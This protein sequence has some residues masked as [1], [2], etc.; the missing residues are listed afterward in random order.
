M[1]VTIVVCSTKDCGRMLNGE[2][3]FFKDDMPFCNIHRT[4]NFPDPCEWN[5]SEGRTA[6]YHEVHASATILVGADGQYRLC[7]DC[8][9]LPEFKQ[10]KKKFINESGVTPV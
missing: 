7:E 9:A 4:L 5:P 6:Y 1:G 8:A 3:C 2:I 10:F